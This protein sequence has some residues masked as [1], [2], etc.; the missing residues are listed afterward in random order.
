MLL[1]NIAIVTSLIFP[2]PFN[3]VVRPSDYT[4]PTGQDARI[5]IDVPSHAEINP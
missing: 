4:F 5:G 3:P 1:Y 2:F